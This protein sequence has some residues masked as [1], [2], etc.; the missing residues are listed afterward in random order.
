MMG[1]ILSNLQWKAL[2]LLIAI[3]LWSLLAGD[4]E[5]VTWQSV[6]IFYKNLPR[7]LEI[8]SGITDRVELEIRGPAGKLTP[9]SLGA[10]AVTVDL[11]SVQAPGERTFNVTGGGINLPMGIVL[12]RAVPSQLR[13]RFDR[14]MAKPVAVEVRQGAPPPP[15]F[16]LFSQE[17]SP[18]ELRIVGPEGQVQQIASAKTDPIDLTGVTG[19]KEFHVHAYVADP[20]VR[21]EG[22]PL[23]TVKVVVGKSEQ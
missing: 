4:P 18:R 14:L 2:A 3:A 16:Q 20:Q 10:T 21:F 1:G 13:L 6:P 19:R 11:S 9:S 15:G 17:V 8:G 12:L 7:D 22:S 23:V 5:L